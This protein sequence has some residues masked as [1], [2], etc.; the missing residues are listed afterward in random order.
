LG[1]NASGRYSQLLR[2]LA[3]GHGNHLANFFDQAG[4][5]A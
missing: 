1:G 2:V 3:G 5:H 4:E